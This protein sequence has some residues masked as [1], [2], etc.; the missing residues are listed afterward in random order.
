MSN[1]SLGSVGAL[2]AALAVL[3]ALSGD[4]LA[5]GPD[6]DCAVGE[7]AYRIYAP[8]TLGAG[9]GRGAIL[10]AHGYGGSAAGVMRNASMRAMADR[11]GV[12]LIAI[13]SAGRGWILPGSPSAPDSDGSIEFDYAIA[14]LDDAIARFDLDPDRILAAGFSGGGMMVWEL[15][16]RRGDRFAGFAP[17]AGVFWRPIPEGCAGRF[18]NVLHVHG[19]SDEVVPLAG[20]P[21]GPARQ[22]DVYD[23]LALAAARGGYATEETVAAEGRLDC[24]RRENGSGDLLELCLHPGGHDFRPEYIERAWRALER[25]GA[26]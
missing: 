20:R 6:T 12:A 8:E 24:A 9:G 15:A 22:G 26:L 23:A 7:R 10:Y 4:A 25:R 16:C 1:V 3:I 14:A 21:I 11:L 19:T 17:I 13:K 2:A 5:C 18:Q